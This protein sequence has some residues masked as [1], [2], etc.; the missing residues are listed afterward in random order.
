VVTALAAP[1]V[2]T[3]IPTDTTATIRTMTSK[4]TAVVRSRRCPEPDNGLLWSPRRDRLI[5]ISSRLSVTHEHETVATHEVRCAR[6][7]PSEIAPVGAVEL[8]SSEATLL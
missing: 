5:Q 8:S 2:A 3:R 4:I 1:S 6:P 7:E